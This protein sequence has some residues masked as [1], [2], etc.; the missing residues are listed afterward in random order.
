MLTF[1]CKQSKD[2]VGVL[3]A[4]LGTPAA[5]TKQAL[6]PYLKQFL[7]DR[8]VIEVNRFIWWFIL[9]GIILN[10]RPKRSAENYSRVW[11]NEGSPLLVTTRTLA[12]ELESSLKNI[13]D[14]LL[15]AFGMRYGEP[16]LD[17]AIDQMLSQGV[18]RI[19][20]LPL[21]PQYAAATSA[22]TYDA[23][24]ARLLRERWV[25]T[26]RVAQPFYQNQ[27]YI[28]AQAEVIN[29]G[30]DKLDFV[31]ERL[32]LSYHGVPKKYVE[33]G[34]PYCCMCNETTSLLKSKIKFPSEKII[35]CYQSRFGKDPW[36][37]PYTDETVIALAQQGAK[38]LA[39]AAPAFVSDCLETVDELGRE[40][41]HLFQENGGEMLSLIPCMNDNPAWINALAS[42]VQNELGG[43]I[44][45]SNKRLVCAQCP[46]GV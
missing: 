28:D 36:L 23:V 19:L 15:V 7:S 44:D 9:N 12:R 29:Q 6:R 20:L 2:R 22:S 16:S 34:D 43:W 26:L 39:V 21:Y 4:Q 24:F 38:K 42:I 33:K 13:D 11:T 17:S 14:S 27:N 1:G 18:R 5:P 25:P 31:P 32:L 30:L 46:A 10:T 40:N 45:G 41:N 3:M 37:T 35:H 8:R